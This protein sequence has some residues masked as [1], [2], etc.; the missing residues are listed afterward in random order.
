MPVVQLCEQDQLLQTVC[1]IGCQENLHDQVQAIIFLLRLTLIT[2]ELPHIPSD[3]HNALLSSPLRCDVLEMRKITVS[4]LQVI[5][6]LYHKVRPFVRFPINMLKFYTDEP[7]TPSLLNH[8]V[9][10]R[11]LQ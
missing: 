10:P 6:Q 8:P 5:C 1:T 3:V 7:I 4:Y 2:H 9:G 11:E